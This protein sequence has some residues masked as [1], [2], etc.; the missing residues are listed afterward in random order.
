LRIKWWSLSQTTG[1]KS[2]EEN[3]CFS[4]CNAGSTVTFVKAYSPEIYDV[5]AG[6]AINEDRASIIVIL[7][8]LL[9]QRSHSI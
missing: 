1:K 7:T 3:F 8:A 4:E 5:T 6:I 2:R 9:K